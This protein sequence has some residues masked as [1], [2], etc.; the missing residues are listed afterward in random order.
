MIFYTGFLSTEDEV[1]PGN[2]GL[3]DAIVVLQWVQKYIDA[4]GGDKNRVTLFGGSSGAM[5]ASLALISPLT[6]GNFSLNKKRLQQM[7]LCIQA[8]T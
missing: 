4:Y 2:Y 1:I 7:N 5:S 8:S 3:K 6:K